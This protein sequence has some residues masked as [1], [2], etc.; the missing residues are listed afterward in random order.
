MDAFSLLLEII[1]V[2]TYFLL[3]NKKENEVVLLGND[4]ESQEK[5]AHEAFDER[6]FEQNKAKH[7]KRLVSRVKSNDTEGSHR[8][9]AVNDNT[10]NM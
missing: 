8:T 9:S 10:K 2:Y 3:R 7:S 1:T 5:L 4:T 6:L